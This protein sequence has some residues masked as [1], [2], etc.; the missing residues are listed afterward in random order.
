[1]NAMMETFTNFGPQLGDA[2]YASGPDIASL[3]L[4]E[5]EMPDL[6]EEFVA[7]QAARQ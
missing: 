6:G 7:C 4:V 5:E 2:R 1:M 3:P